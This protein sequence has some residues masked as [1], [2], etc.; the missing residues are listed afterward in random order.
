MYQKHPRPDPLINPTGIEAYRP[1]EVADRI[2]E[3]GVA[4]ASLPLAPLVTLSVLAGAFIALGAAGFTAVMAGTDAGLGP[5]RLL[6]GVVFSLG[7]IL[8][9]VAGAE[10]FT[11]NALIVMAWVDGR[12]S[13]MALLRNWLAALVG[14]A[15][16]AVII[17][18]LMWQSGLL[19]GAQGEMARAIAT[20]KAAM[21]FGEALARGI[22]CNVLVCLA[23][24][25][26]FA[27]R[28]VADKIL[29]IIWPISAFVLLGYEHSVANFY[30]FPAGIAAG[31]DIG[32]GAV[33]ANLAPVII[34]NL[35]GGAGGVAI[36]YWLA[37]GRREPDY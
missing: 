12:I 37:Y 32:M 8:V 34:G 10:L 13:L 14:N 9:I 5:A 29:A 1:A 4:K 11:G 35:I 21:S 23:V 30:F 6:G 28:S 24:W 36:S 7:L 22:L 31:A 16:G 2:E 15:A 26:S 20:S 19:S 3:A 27:C 17:A 33:I 18:L 25:L